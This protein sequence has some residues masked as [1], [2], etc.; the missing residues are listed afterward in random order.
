MNKKKMEG[1][2]RAFDIS[3]EELSTLP[4]DEKKAIL[5]VI[6]ERIALLGA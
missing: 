2:K 5:E 4:M 3:D 1:I 6:K